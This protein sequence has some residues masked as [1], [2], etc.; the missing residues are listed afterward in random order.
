MFHTL[1]WRES[2]AENVFNDLTAVTDAQLPI[3]NGHF[4]PGSDME[5]FAMYAGSVTLA[6][7]RLTTPAIR[8]TS[9]ILIR[10]IS[11]AL[12]PPQDPN[13][14]IFAPDSITVRGQEEIVLEA[15]QTGGAAEVVSAVMLIGDKI[16]PVP[17][18]DVFV[19][20]ATAATTLVAGAWT[21][22]TYTLDSTLP[23]G[24]YGVVLLESFG[25]TIIASR[26]VF[27][28]VGMRPGMLGFATVGL[29]LPYPIYSYRMGLWGRFVT[30]SLPRIEV[31]ANAADTAQTFHIHI[32]KM[33][34]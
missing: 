10:P 13:M 12:L 22:V 3:V 4:M 5:I 19:I 7:A 9:P 30:Y 21:Q 25:T 15:L 29:R 6:Q 16:D 24:V 11:P 27:D 31:L 33:A 2:I 17:P 1:A 14:Q 18:G 26:M 23:A 32:V 28:N 20:R 8:K 34:G